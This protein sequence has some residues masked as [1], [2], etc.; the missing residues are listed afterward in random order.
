M[1]IFLLRAVI[2]F[3]AIIVLYSKLT[4]KYVQPYQLNMVISKP[5]GGKS[6][7]CVKLAHYYMKRGHHVFSTEKIE[8]PILDPKT[9]KKI[10]VETTPIKV[11]Q[12]YRYQFPP[13]SVI[14]VDE[15]GV[16]FHN[17]QFKNF[18]K[19]NVAFFKRY[20]HDKLIIWGFS[21]SFDVDLTIR[22][23]VSQFWVLEKYARV[24]AVAR[25]LIMKPVVVHPTGDAPS[26]I[27][28]DFVEDPKLLRPVLGGMKVTFIPHWVKSFDSYEIPEDQMKE[29]DIDLTDTPLPY[30]PKTT[31]RFKD[32]TKIAFANLVR[33]G[34]QGLASRRMHHRQKT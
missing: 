9:R 31:Y 30:R 33:R 29:R 3:S 18:D 23:L 26:S 5:G 15:M 20:R 32:S 17:R 13:D 2:V 14:L 4:A 27:Q 22:N 6:T 34:R 8:V 1:K 11:N 25:R 10:I 19:R 16:H 21:Q 7:M 28:D 12:L 24:F